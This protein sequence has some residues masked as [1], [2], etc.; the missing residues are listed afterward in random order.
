MTR[1]EVQ[2]TDGFWKEKQ[3]MNIAVTIP[4]VYDR[5]FETGR[6][7]AFKCLWKPEYTGQEG[8]PIKPHIFWDS[9]V[10]KWI[11]SVSYV[12]MTESHPELE[13][14]VESIINNIEKNQWEDGYINSFF[15][16]IEPEHR[17]TYRD[18]HELYCCGHLLEAAIAYYEATGKD[19]FLN[20]MKKYVDLIYKVFYIEK[21]AK[22]AT[23][24]HEEIELALVK[25]YRLTKDKKYLDLASY[26]VEARGVDRKGDEELRNDLGYSSLQDNEQIRE[27]KEASG[28]AVRAS[29]F[30]SAVADLALEKNDK[31][32]FNVCDRIFDDI[33]DKKMYITGATGQDYRG[34]AFT[35][36]YDLPSYT[37]YAET[38]AS[39]A[40]ALFANRMLK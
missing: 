31:E 14:K 25:L 16:V 6:I 5:F 24:G 37:A 15:T 12:L 11:E 1:K 35:V 18:D 10:A 22:F 26:F 40:L 17:F 38:C 29:Y 23:P 36:S 32:L 13:E 34:E 7:D 30:Y 20:I 4:A 39:I 33:V 3:K 2:I 9:D 21:S 27:T 19:R 8:K 28:H